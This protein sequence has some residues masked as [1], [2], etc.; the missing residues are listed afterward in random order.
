MKT[1]IKSI[2]RNIQFN[3][4]IIGELLFMNSIVDTNP[5]KVQ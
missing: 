3:V 4:K 5:L 2:V 1:T